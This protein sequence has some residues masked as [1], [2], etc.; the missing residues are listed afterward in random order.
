MSQIIHLKSVDDV[1]QLLDTPKPTH[2]L[3]AIY[4]HPAGLEYN[5]G[6]TRISSDLYTISLKHGIE[7]EFGYG[8][9]TYDFR[10]GTMT[11]MAPN[12]VMIPGKGSI[13][14]QTENWNIYFHPD[15]IHGSNLGTHIDDYSFFDYDTTEALHISEEERKTLTELAMKIKREIENNIDKH[16]Q[17]LIVTNLELIL[18]Y[19]LRYY[20]R[21]F[22]TRSNFH[23][24]L[25]ARF[26]RILKD[27]FKENLQ[28]DK[29]LPTVKYCGEA[30]NISPNYL[31]DLL[32]KETDRNAQ[33][34][35]HAYVIDKAKHL[36][37]SS[38]DSVKQVAYH[39]GFDYSQHF[40]KLFKAKT[41]MSP[42]EFRT[43]N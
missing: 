32:K 17:K 14:E 40:S 29:G 35:I 6:D 8:R 23:Q 3:I 30:L 34:H 13:P 18:D 38:D 20:D 25:V 43:L 9:N 1:S 31:S 22:Y 36:L 2:P 27:Y 11:F 15:L 24:D 26:E 10:E 19:C 21:Q 42:M 4:P 39:L 7:G 28:L 16:S 33:D 37:L 5:Y 12:Q 41:G